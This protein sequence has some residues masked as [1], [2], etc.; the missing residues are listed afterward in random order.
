MLHLMPPH[1]INEL[2]HARCKSSTSSAAQ[3]AITESLSDAESPVP[4]EGTS[5]V[6]GPICLVCHEHTTEQTVVITI[7]GHTFCKMCHRRLLDK[8]P[9][10]RAPYG[11]PVSTSMPSDASPNVPSSNAPSPNVPSPLTLHLAPA[12]VTVRITLRHMKRAINLLREMNTIEVSSGQGRDLIEQFNNLKSQIV[13]LNPGDM[14]DIEEQIR[15]YPQYGN[16]KLTVFVWNIYAMYAMYAIEQ[17][18][19]RFDTGHIDELIEYVNKRF[20]SHFSTLSPWEWPECHC[21]LLGSDIFIP[22]RCGI[23]QKQCRAGKPYTYRTTEGVTKNYSLLTTNP[24]VY[25][26][27]IRKSTVARLEQEFNCCLAG[28]HPSTVFTF[29]NT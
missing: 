9:V 10:C 27:N 14:N 11:I 21:M 4:N 19:F 22:H 3:S 20:L 6:V 5:S 13:A 8:C 7:C 24:I 25:M 29:K 26:P 18:Y 28:R 23:N 17:G 1:I 2:Y 15:N 12:A 16:R